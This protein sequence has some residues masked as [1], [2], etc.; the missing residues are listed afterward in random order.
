MNMKYLI[1]RRIWTV[2]NHDSQI[3]IT[4]LEK[5]IS[6]LEHKLNAQN[7]NSKELNDI[8]NGERNRFLKLQNKFNELDAKNSEYLNIIRDQK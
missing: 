6:E 7:K 5:Y 1:Y 8:Y 3:K 4:N 2:N